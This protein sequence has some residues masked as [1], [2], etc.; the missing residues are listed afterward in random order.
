MPDNMIDD[1]A[2]VGSSS[3][4]SY[5][6]EGVHIQEA[7]NDVEDEDEFKVMNVEESKKMFEN[8]DGSEEKAKHALEEHMRKTFEVARSKKSTLL[9]T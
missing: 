7:K 2:G 3:S 4:S 9:A 5:E 8:N 1:G 6:F